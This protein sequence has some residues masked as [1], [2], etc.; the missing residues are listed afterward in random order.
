MEVGKHWKT[1]GVILAY[2]HT[3][4]QKKKKI[5]GSVSSSLSIGQ[6]LGCSGIL[7][8]EDEVSLNIYLKLTIN[9]TFGK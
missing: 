2:L 6:R 8:F 4:T 9:L 3:H 5:V 7:I 1:E